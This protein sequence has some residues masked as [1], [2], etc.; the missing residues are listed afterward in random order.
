[1][2]A[3]VVLMELGEYGSL[4]EYISSTS[5]P[6]Y[7]SDSDVDNLP[8]PHRSPRKFPLKQICEDRAK[9]IIRQILQA[10]KYLHGR[11]LVC[12]YLHPMDIYITAKEAVGGRLDSWEGLHSRSS[13]RDTSRHTVSYDGSCRERERDEVGISR[14][15]PR[16]MQS[17]EPSIEEGSDEDEQNYEVATAGPRLRVLLTNLGISRPSN[18]HWRAPP[19]ET[20]YLAP[21]IQQAGM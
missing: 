10:L 5:V 15:H 2:V 12:R 21:E 7:N 17:V 4:A 8:S 20:H 18:F 14:S 11:G 6:D 1:M 19:V 16:V 9:V 13:V 3:F